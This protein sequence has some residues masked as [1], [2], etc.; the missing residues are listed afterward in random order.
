MKVIVVLMI[1]YIGVFSGNKLSIAVGAS[2]KIPLIV[3]LYGMVMD[4]WI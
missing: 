3:L 1:K 4:K 2:Y